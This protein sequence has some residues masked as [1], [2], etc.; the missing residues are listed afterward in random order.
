MPPK[1]LRETHA[2]EALDLVAVW[3]RPPGS[4]YERD[5]PAAGRLRRLAQAVRAQRDDPHTPPFGADHQGGREPDP[6]CPS[7]DQGRLSLEPHSATSILPQV[8]DP[9]RVCPTRRSRTDSRPASTARRPYRP[10]PPSPACTPAVR[11][12]LRRAPNPG[13]HRRERG[14]CQSV[15]GRHHAQG[16]HRLS[17]VVADRGARTSQAQTAFLVVHGEVLP[18]DPFQLRQERAPALDRSSG[19]GLQSPARQ[20]SRELRRFQGGKQDLPRCRCVSRHSADPH[21]DPEGMRALDQMNAHRAEGVQHPQVHGLARLG[22]QPLHD[23]LGHLAQPE[24]LG[25]TTSEGK[26]PIVSW[27]RS[28]LAS[29]ST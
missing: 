26:Q 27:Y 1:L 24:P 29:F 22:S 4:V 13:D 19:D 7:R 21:M 12:L 15:A 25:G 28:L 3:T 23:R 11:D 14:W 6:L 20:S 2:V 17:A 8:A 9:P 5:P 16:C 18:P 10:A